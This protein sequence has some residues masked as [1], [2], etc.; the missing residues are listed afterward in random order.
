MRLAVR[1]GRDAGVWISADGK[2]WRRL[3]VTGDPP[4]QTT[5]AVLLPGGVLLSDGATTWYGEAAGE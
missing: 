3:T 5:Q 4:Q 2:A 1:G